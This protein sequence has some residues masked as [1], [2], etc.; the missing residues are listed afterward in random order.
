MFCKLAL[1]NVTQSMRDYTVYFLTLTFGV[2]V[3]YVFNSLDSQ[4]LMMD[5]NS[6]QSEI[7]KLITF[8]LDGVSVFVSFVLAG[9]ILYANTFMIRRRKK[10]LGVY[11]LLGMNKSR[12]SFILLAETLLIGLLA[13]V[14]GLAVGVALS[15]G[16]SVVTANMF[17]VTLKEFRFVFSLA[18]FAKSILYFSLIF[19]V[20]MLFNTF[21]ISRCK[22]ID[23]LQADRR[24]QKLRAG[25]LWVSVILFL[26]S[27]ACLGC[28]YAMILHNRMLVLDNEFRLSIGLGIVGTFLFFLSLSGF[29]LRIIKSSRRMY[30][31]GLN[32]FV[33]RQVNSQIRTAYLSMTF[34]C[35]MLLLSIGILSVSSGMNSSISGNLQRGTPYDVTFKAEKKDGVLPD[36]RQEMKT[37][38]L[39]LQVVL[40][41]SHEYTDKDSGVRVNNITAPYNN[42]LSSFYVS[43]YERTNMTAIAIGD[44]NALLALQGEEALPLKDGEYRLLSTMEYTQEILRRYVTESHPITVAGVSLSLAAPELLSVP[45]ETSS[46]DGIELLLI[47]PDEVAA[48]LAPMSAALSGNYAPGQ[49][50][51]T[52]EWFLQFATLGMTDKQENFPQV[53]VL[54]RQLVL[55]MGMGLKAIF[56]FIGV[57]LGIIF[58]IASAAVLAL[59]QLS[60]ASDNMVRYRLLRQLGTPDRMIDHSIFAQVFI[61]FSI[62]LVLAIIHSIVGIQ[63]A[64]TLIN[65]YGTADSWGSVVYTAVILLLIYGGYFLATFFGCRAMIKGKR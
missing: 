56:L 44:V 57:Y 50:D 51:G 65:A 55:Q 26:L 6:L 62:P 31:R 46:G 53:D 49:K 60:Q 11:M 1:K 28:A 40:A 18:A 14:A 16:L 48:K 27:A 38:G 8:L 32:M 64:G 29:L 20:V 43:K 34:I 7:F 35:L 15:Q 30:L 3:F 47:V 5:V 41:E 13:L 37:A 19:V 45:L 54:T 4:Q 42:S 22:L 23:L 17:A 24:N 10:E 39:D 25:R 59:Q 36:I 63:A 21:S 2:C 9:L 58:L 52:E 12:I 61:Y 33:L